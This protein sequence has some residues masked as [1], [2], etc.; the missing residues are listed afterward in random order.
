MDGQPC[1]G[2]WNEA[3]G[4]NVPLEHL[5]TIGAGKLAAGGGPRVG[6]G[7]SRGRRRTC[8]G[9]VTSEQGR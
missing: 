5:V 9:N 7:R 6:R 1:N 2:A 4:V 8:W 3:A